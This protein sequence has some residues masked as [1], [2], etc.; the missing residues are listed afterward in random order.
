ME[1]LGRHGCDVLGAGIVETTG[2]KTWSEVEH[3]KKKNRVAKLIYINEA[4]ECTY[5]HR[6]ERQRHRGLQSAR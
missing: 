1:E 6:Y 2:T 3:W 4:G 5:Y